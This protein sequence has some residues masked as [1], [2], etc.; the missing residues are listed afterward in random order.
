[1]PLIILIVVL[2]ALKYFEVSFVENLSWWWIIGLFGVAFIWFEFL[3]R[4]FG[5]DKRKAHEQLEK[6][7]QERVRKAFD[8]KKR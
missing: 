1:M 5:R 7:R 2:S 3:E 6:Q 8:T 4:I